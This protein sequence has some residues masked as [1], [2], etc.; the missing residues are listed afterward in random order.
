[1]KIIGSALSLNSSGRRNNLGEVKIEIRER[2][3]EHND[4]TEQRKETENERK[5]I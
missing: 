5:E 4:R 1:M 3:K 2:E